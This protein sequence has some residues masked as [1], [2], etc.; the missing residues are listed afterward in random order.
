MA[1]T[2]RQVTFVFFGAEQRRDV[3]LIVVC[4]DAAV[5]WGLHGRGAQCILLYIFLNSSHL[6]LKRLPVCVFY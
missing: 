3:D 2:W 5:D 1:L 4:R 6:G